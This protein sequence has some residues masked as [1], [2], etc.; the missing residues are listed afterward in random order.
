[1]SLA[2]PAIG[3]FGQSLTCAGGIVSGILVARGQTVYSGF[4]R[5]SWGGQLMWDCVKTGGSYSTKEQDMSAD[6]QDY[7]VWEDPSAPSNQPKPEEPESK[8]SWFR[9][10]SSG[11]GFRPQTWQGWV[12]LIVAV[13]II[14]AVVISIR[15]GL[16]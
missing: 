3:A 15:R 16:F 8:Q 7:P 4:Q 13:L 9:R 10:N 11:V 12:V 1:V 5:L 14:L 2:T 6:K